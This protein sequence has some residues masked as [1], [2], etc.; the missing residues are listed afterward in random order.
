LQ[1]LTATTRER[2]IPT[3]SAPPATVEDVDDFMRRLSEELDLTAFD[4]S[5]DNIAGS[6]TAGSSP[7]AL[8][9]EVLVNY[10]G[11]SFW[12]VWTFPISEWHDLEEHREI[13][14][15]RISPIDA[16]SLR[17]KEVTTRL[18]GAELRHFAGFLSRS[19][20]ENDYLWGRLHGAERLIDIVFNAEA[21][22]NALD[23]V[24]IK[25][26]KAATFRSILDTEDRC[27]LDKT[28][29]LAIRKEIDE[30]ERP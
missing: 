13:R 4:R 1:R 25:K 10:L 28:L 26:I 18:R 14:V 30:L 19:V 20:R 9:R 12:D 21:A 11:F 22:E 23:E 17:S 3:V 16:T 15:D 8:R 29:V 6:S 24:D 5:V 7:A 2:G 27:L